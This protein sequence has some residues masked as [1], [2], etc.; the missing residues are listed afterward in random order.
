MCLPEDEQVQRAVLGSW[1]AELS[2]SLLAGVQ[3]KGPL[4]KGQSEIPVAPDTG[5]VFF[6]LY[7]G[8]VHCPVWTIPF[9]M[10]QST[11]CSCV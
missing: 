1:L 10:K 9:C 5:Q 4:Q 11:M 2:A 3:D 8:R 6:R 7:C